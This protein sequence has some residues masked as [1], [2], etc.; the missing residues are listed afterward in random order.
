MKELI[1]LHQSTSSKWYKPWNKRSL[2]LNF[3]GF[4]SIA[5]LT[6]LFTVFF[7][8]IMMEIGYI[9]LYFVMLFLMMV[10]KRAYWDSN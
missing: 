7:D 1:V 4:M 3:V 2:S 6:A 9:Y 5:V 8:I 10:N